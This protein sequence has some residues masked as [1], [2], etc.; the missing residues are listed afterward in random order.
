MNPAASLSVAEGMQPHPGTTALLSRGHRRALPISASVVIA[1]TALAACGSAAT[2]AGSAPTAAGSAVTVSLAKNSQLGQQILVG[3]NGRT[4]YLFEKDTN[5]KSA[6]TQSCTSVWP[7]LT[8][9]GKPRAGSGI[10]AS[11]LGTIPRSGGKTQVTYNKHPLYYYASDT[12]AGQANGQG[13][14]QFGALWY[15]LSSRG[16]T[17]TSKS[18]STGGGGGY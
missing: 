4:L 18:S 5:G 6:C 8:T 7:P 13:L 14:N 11:L 10:S 2:S 9:H 17:I 12:S 1:A 3:N 15:V 16:N